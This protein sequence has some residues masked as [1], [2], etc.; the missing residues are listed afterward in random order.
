MPVQARL[1]LAPGQ[2]LSGLAEV[3]AAV[4]AAKGVAAPLGD[5][6]TPAAEAIASSLLAG[7]SKAVLLGNAAAEHPQAA[8]LLALAQWI[9]EQTGATVGYLGTGGNAVGLQAAGVE[10]RAAGQGATAQGARCGGGGG[11]G[12]RRHHVG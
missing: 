12:R 7:E 2:W 3:A 11:L 9:G 5:A 10:P 1:T 4:A 8:D 6:S